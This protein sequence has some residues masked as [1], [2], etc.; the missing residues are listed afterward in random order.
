MTFEYTRRDFIKITS[1]GTLSAFLPINCQTKAEKEIKEFLA[2]VGTYTSGKSEGIYICRLDLSTGELKLIKSVT[3]VK[4]PSF[5]A[6]DPKKKYLYSVNEVAKFEGKPGGGV[7]AFLI[8]QETGDLTFLNHQ[9]TK[10]GAPCYV[11]VDKTSSFVLTANY[12]SGNLSIFPILDDGSLGEMSDFVQHEGSGLDKRRQKAPH[13][14][15]IVIAPDNRYVFSAD[16]GIDKIMI[17]KLDTKNGKLIPNDVP[18]A[19]LAPGAGP[20]HFTIHQNEK[21][22]YVINEINSTVTAFEYD[23]VKGILTEIQTIPT[24]PKDFEGTSYC[25]DIHVSPCGKFLYGSNR[26]HDSIV[27]Y[28]IDENTGRLEYIGT[29]S[30][31][32]SWPRNFA[33]DPTGAFLLVE[34]QKTDN[35]VIFQID[36]D[37]GKLNQT[38]NITEIPSPVCIKMIPFPIS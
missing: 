12:G 25:A 1:M 28:S 17:Y 38:G 20:R 23:K 10:G 18:Y 9:F 31:Q 36:R 5:L 33:I 22:A 32:G 4:N 7:S 16:L 14:H 11:S 19:E 35:I 2:Y 15:C 21:Y 30:T 6:I 37:T 3:G 24:L 34:N 8:D 13:A 26:G 29:E 27:I